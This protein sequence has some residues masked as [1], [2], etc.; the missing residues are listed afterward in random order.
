[1]PTRP[2]ETRRGLVRPDHT[3]V[4]IAVRT[5]IATGGGAEQIDTLRMVVV[6]QTTRDL[7][8]GL[9]LGH[10]P[11]SCTENAGTREDAHCRPREQA[12]EQQVASSS[13]QGFQD[14][15]ETP[16]ITPH[17]PD[18]KSTRLNSSHLGISY[19]VF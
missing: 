5:A 19:A 17:R 1:M 12:R 9:V 7:R 8:D 2:V 11:L 18:R 16:R 13:V 6:H 4:E 10:A 14:I 15:V 3:E